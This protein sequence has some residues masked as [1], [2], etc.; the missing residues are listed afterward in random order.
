MPN[1]TDL[2]PDN[3]LESSGLASLGRGLYDILSGKA[4]SWE[5]VVPRRSL[6]EVAPILQHLLPEVQPGRTIPQTISNSATK[7]T[8]L[9]PTE[10][11]IQRVAGPSE[12]DL[13]TTVEVP[14][15]FTRVPATFSLPESNPY[16]GFSNPLQGWKNITDVVSPTIT[17]PEEAPVAQTTGSFIDTRGIKTSEPTERKTTVTDTTSTPKVSVPAKTVK[18][19]GSKKKATTTAT[20]VNVSSSKEIPNSKNTSNSGSNDLNINFL[21]HIN[22]LLPLLAA[23]GLGYL[24]A[25]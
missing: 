4:R 24:L 17:I 25:K 1:I 21:S 12:N 19:T 3:S 7:A 6:Q 2:R 5:P 20:K 16:V 8:S 22:D 14:G 23:G 15:S 9:V 11:L 18:S 10:V 13:Q